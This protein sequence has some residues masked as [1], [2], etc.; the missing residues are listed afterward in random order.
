MP[1][2]NYKGINGEN[3][4]LD[5]D[6][7]E[8]KAIY[9][10]AIKKGTIKETKEKP[11]FLSKEDLKNRLAGGALGATS[12]GFMGGVPGALIGGAAGAIF[13]PEDM[14]DVGIMV[15]G[16]P[17][18]GK[19]SKLISGLT[20]N[21]S[22][23]VKGGSQ[24]LGGMTYGAGENALSK[25]L[26]GQDPKP[27][28][29]SELA[30]IV[31]GGI[32][33]L[34]TNM[35]GMK[36]TPAARTAK[37]FGTQNP[38]E[39]YKILERGSKSLD[40][41]REA[42]QE[43]SDFTINLEKEINRLKGESSTIAKTEKKIQGQLSKRDY[44]QKVQDRNLE[45]S[46]N[47]EKTQ[48]KESIRVMENELN[49]GKRI[50]GELDNQMKANPYDTS[51][52]QRKKEITDQL[53]LKEMD[54]EQA[55]KDFSLKEIEKFEAGK[56][57]PQQLKSNTTLKD[58]FVRIQQRQQDIKKEILET[59]QKIQ[60]GEFGNLA[61]NNLFKRNSQ[62]AGKSTEDLF[63]DL[64]GQN[65]QVIKD[66][67][68]HYQNKGKDSMM[69]E[70]IVQHIM[71]NSFD[72]VTN[73]V[74]NG[75]TYLKQAGKGNVIDRMQHIFGDRDTAERVVNS[76]KEISESADR[77]TKNRIS[78]TMVGTVG[79]GLA[80]NIGALL[81][82]HG[83]KKAASVAGGEAATLAY[84]KW[85][86]LLNKMASSKKFND[87]FKDWMTEGATKE[88]LEKNQYLL[89]QIRELSYTIPED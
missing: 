44:K 62:E 5:L 17:A 56:I 64:I 25:G 11:E 1:I 40:A 77:I 36:K 9:D 4:P 57:D 88:I 13:P 59:E 76:F 68:E 31:M 16:G 33:G 28:S 61:L 39:N 53:L 21:A 43:A 20:K 58:N 78:S 45:K 63:D 85:G 42:Q 66:F 12:G 3:V 83:L 70:A 71:Q 84:L 50:I 37:A 55:R 60:G 51:L 38:S 49:D 79:T 32:P 47:A 69:R 34:F 7:P 72:P 26:R 80:F 15:G 8:D 14:V 52:I 86:T 30:G 65:P 54:I 22:N 74:G 10:E 46:F 27:T 23:L 29:A 75:F 89:S 73:S 48:F 87:A 6:D 41:A 81:S 35:S 19:V 24:V 82:G 2:K 18:A 67:F